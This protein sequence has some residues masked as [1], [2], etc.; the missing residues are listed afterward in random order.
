M[1]NIFLLYYYCENVH[2]F[3]KDFVFLVKVLYRGNDRILV[4]RSNHKKFIDC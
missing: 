2:I 4:A 3:I 1:E